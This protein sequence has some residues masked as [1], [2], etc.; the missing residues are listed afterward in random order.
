MLKN[1]S[2]ALSLIAA[3][4]LPSSAFAMSWGQ[5]IGYLKKPFEKNLATQAPSPAPSESSVPVASPPSSPVSTNSGPTSSSVPATSAPTASAPVNDVPVS[6]ASPSTTP[7]YVAPVANYSAS[8]SSGSQAENSDYH[9]G[10][11]PA[12]PND[13]KTS[14]PF[15]FDSLMELIR[16]NQVTSVDQLIPLL[17]QSYR[18]NFV[19]MLQSGSLQT[20]TRKHPR[21]IAYGNSLPI[22]TIYPGQNTDRLY[23]AFQSDTDKAGSDT[24]LPNV[25]SK[26]PNS[27]EVIE[28]HPETRDYRFYQLDFPLSGAPIPVNPDT[29]KDCH[30]TP[31]RPNWT[32]YPR[33]DG[34]FGNNNALSGE[35]NYTDVPE[36]QADV[37]KAIDTFK[38]DNDR[39]K[40][41]DFSGYMGTTLQLDTLPAKMSQKVGSQLQLR[42]LALIRSS[43]DYDKFKYAFAGA[44]LGC[45]NYSD[46]FDARLQDTLQ[47]NVYANLVNV[48]K[49]LDTTQEELT[50]P[51]L[52]QMTGRL[53]EKN[54][55]H[56]EDYSKDVLTT[57]WMRF[58]LEGRNNSSLLR[59][60]LGLPPFDSVSVPQWNYD[61]VGFSNEITG[62]GEQFIDST[63]KDFPG[64]QNL[65][66]LSTQEGEYDFNK[67][68]LSDQMRT[69]NGPAAATC[70]QL[71][72]KSRAATA[73][74]VVP[75]PK[76]IQT[77]I[78]T[79]TQ[80]GA[81]ISSGLGLFQKYCTTCHGANGAFV[82]PLD[83]LDQLKAYRTSAGRSISQRLSGKEMPPPTFKV[84]PTDGER[85][86]MIQALDN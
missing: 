62:L 77:T 12:D 66:E 48:P 10:T 29:C 16:S 53:I 65:E 55:T 32:A 43:P 72:S 20:A 50:F 60:I 86:A 57:T 36:S 23:L 25:K 84:Q 22:E 5:L 58:L 81:I 1:N 3:A 78:A 68:G 49:T 47:Q 46:F 19:L 2:I 35:F 82:L 51:K 75:A 21:V 56:F 18:S 4:A 26:L 38:L 71:A 14:K 13:A 59:N 8:T 17:P 42:D 6:S 24:D 28:W 52:W 54:G 64:F 15:T 85:S 7:S 70:Q 41:F 67:N 33:W 79:P 61:F 31:L 83:N 44:F 40:P 45:V 34:A 37:Q 39:I 11:G 27:L 30:G 74:Y 69:E 63:A 9:Y 76:L 73:G 80:N